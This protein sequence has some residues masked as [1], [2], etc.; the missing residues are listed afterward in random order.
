MATMFDQAVFG[1][2]VIGFARGAEIRSAV[3]NQQHTVVAVVFAHRAGAFAMAAAD[4]AVRIGER[5][6]QLPLARA[7]LHQAVGEDG[8]VVELVAR[9]D[10][11]D[12]VIEAIADHPQGGA[13]TQR[14]LHEL[15]ERGIDAQRR[16]VLVDL[17]ARGVQ[18]RDL[19]GHA[20]GRTDLA[21]A[22]VAFQHPPFGR[23]EMI[24]QR[25]GDVLDGDGAVEVAQDVPL[26]HGN[27]REAARR[28]LAA[29][30]APEAFRRLSA[31]GWRLNSPRAAD[32][33]AA[34]CSTFSSPF[35]TKGGA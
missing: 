34:I 21:G 26:G 4:P 31:T 20:L 9:E 27:S 24:E 14:R 10:R 30:L 19:A 23:R 33:L 35:G 11:A 2:H 17:I 5:C 13:C 29:I 28:K 1:E 32:V 3:A 8:Q 12:R 6:F 15:L 16:E 18:Q 25:V 22:P 7:D